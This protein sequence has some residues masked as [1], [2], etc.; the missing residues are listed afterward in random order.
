MFMSAAVYFL[1]HWNNGELHENIECH[2]KVVYICEG[3]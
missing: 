1:K 2:G 3:R